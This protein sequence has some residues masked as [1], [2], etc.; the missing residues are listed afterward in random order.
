M[1][2]KKSFI[3]N[4]E[5]VNSYGFI[6]RNAGAKLERFNANPIMLDLHSRDNDKVLGR[7]E[8]LRVEGSLMLADP[9]WDVDDPYAAGI[10][11]KV[12]RGFIKGCS[13]GAVPIKT[14]Y[15][16]DDDMVEVVEWELKEISIA[17]VP[18]NAGSLVLVDAKGQQLT[19]D[20]LIEL[21][22]KVTHNP[23]KNTMSFKNLKVFAKAINLADTATEEEVLEAVQDLHN[24][25]IGLADE[26]S[27]L[28][29]KVGKLEAENN[30]LKDAQKDN[31]KNMAIALVDGA[32][33][34]NRILAGERD[35]YIELAE[36]N[37]ELT[38]KLLDKK[39]AYRS[40]TERIEGGAG[41][42]GEVKLS[43]E[44]KSMNWDAAF[45]AGKTEFIRLN[46]LEHFKTIYKAKFNKEYTGA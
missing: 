2:D 13:L 6:M 19:R 41:A 16:E 20:A 34:G 8:N 35:E 45:K 26:N 46:D 5:S 11:G 32:I 42:P 21:S 22:D 14:M 43:D 12:D 23:I 18:S 25:N 1:S 31:T 24:T 10:Q 38:K 36:N 3:I 9:V 44:I 29:K 30:K 40:V 39:V 17:S 7:W 37:Y 28:T 4:D 27:K 15:N 33:T